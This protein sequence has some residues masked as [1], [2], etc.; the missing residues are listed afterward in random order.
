MSLAVHAF[1]DQTAEAQRL[2][3][4]LRAPLAIVDVHTFPDGEIVPRVPPPARTTIV[5]RSLHQPNIKLV[6]LLLA[7]DA[8]RRNGV[9][10]LVLVAPYL[11][12]MRQ[13]TA[14]NIGE[15]ISQ[16]V[17]A[18]L[19]DAAFDRIV[20][21]DPH[22]HRTASLAELFPTCV[23]T[24]L[25]GADA[26]AS[27]LRAS[28]LAPETLVVGP[29]IESGPWVRR[30]AEPLGLG[31]ATFSKQRRG[32]GDVDLRMPADFSPADRPVLLV[33]DICSTGGTLRGATALLKS[34]G[35][36]PVTIFVTHALGGADVADSLSQ[37]GAAGFIATDSCPNP[38]GKV[39]LAELLA[40]A[41]KDLADV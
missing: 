21:V 19:L 28:P 16:R 15:P 7:A 5:Y 4:A 29:D 14:F 9:Q 6:E 25:F 40:Q 32:D 39:H 23:C 31:Y 3:S 27:Y 20:T 36:G 41:V 1:P 2:A 11:P 37:A 34:S 8:W 26:L 10:Q 33:D 18:S 38:A 24:H 17:V 22:L 35:S 12:Y 30:I 13:D